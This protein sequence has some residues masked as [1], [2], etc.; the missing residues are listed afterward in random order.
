MTCPLTIDLGAYLLGAL[1]PAE[2]ERVRAHLST[3]PDCRDEHGQLRGLPGRLSMLTPYDLG[4]LETTEPS[5]AMLDDLLRRA[6]E[7]TRR[8]TRRRLV[9]GWSAA[10][11][12]AAAVAGYQRYTNSQ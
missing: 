12:L 9:A 5:P 1:D 11:V 6:A 2:E 8:R 10:A 7:D 3:C 4:G